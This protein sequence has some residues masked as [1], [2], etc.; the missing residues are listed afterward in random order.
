M[1]LLEPAR[2]EEALTGEALGPLPRDGIGTLERLYVAEI[3]PKRE[4]CL[5]AVRLDGPAR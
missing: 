2:R 1:R 3:N 4:P 5:T